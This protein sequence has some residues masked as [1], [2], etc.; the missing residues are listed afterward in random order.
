[1]PHEINGGE[2]PPMSQPIPK[3]CIYPWQKGYFLALC[4]RREMSFIAWR[5]SAYRDTAKHDEYLMWRDKAMK[6]AE[7]INK[8]FQ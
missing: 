6:Y 4:E 8:R 1:M 3:G 2:A 5:Q 7:Q